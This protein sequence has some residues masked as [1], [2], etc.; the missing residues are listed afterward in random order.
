MTNI[1]CDV[2]VFCPLVLAHL[3]DPEDEVVFDGILGFAPW[4]AQG[5]A[6]SLGSFLLLTWG[7]PSSL[8]TFGGARGRGGVGCRVGCCGCGRGHL[9]TGECTS[10]D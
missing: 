8:R 1:K 2:L 7:L 3:T 6:C 9:E 4:S 5:T 10:T